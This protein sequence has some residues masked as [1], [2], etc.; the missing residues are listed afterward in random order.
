MLRH[1][2][3]GDSERD[4]ECDPALRRVRV[5]VRWEIVDL[6]CFLYY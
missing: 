5:R 6:F 2:I 1:V 3:Y 4:T